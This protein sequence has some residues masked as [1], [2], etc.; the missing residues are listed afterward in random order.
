MSTLPVWERERE[1]REHCSRWRWNIYIMSVYVEEPSTLLSFCPLNF[2]HPL[3]ISAALVLPAPLEFCTLGGPTVLQL[4]THTH[5]HTPELENSRPCKVLACTT[6][7]SGLLFLWLRRS[8]RETQLYR[9]YKERIVYQIS[10]SSY[11]G[12]IYFLLIWEWK[13]NNKDSFPSPHT[14]K[15]W[16]H[17]PYVKIV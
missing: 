2:L 13:K 12:N 3:N 8:H 5:T 17:G 15:S 16:S 9:S 11:Q 6:V 4:G 7:S 14:S 1:V 10:F